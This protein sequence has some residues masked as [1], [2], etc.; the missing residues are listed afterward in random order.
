MTSREAGF[1]IA[2]L[3]L[4]APFLMFPALAGAGN[5]ELVAVLAM[6]TLAGAV[7]LARHSGL[8]A[9][10]AALVAPP[11]ALFAVTAVIGWGLSPG[12]VASINHFSGIG[13][14]L[15]AMAILA[16]WCQSAQRLA[17][18]TAAVLVM[19]VVVLSIGFRST[20][21]IHKR[22]VFLSDTKAVPPPVIPLPLGGIHKNEVVNPNAL[23]AT[24]MMIL[25]VGVAVAATTASLPWS[26]LMRALG[27]GSALWAAAIVALMQSRS[28]WLSAIIV[29]WLWSRSWLG[30]RLWRVVTVVMV[31]IGGAAFFFL[32]DHPRSG[33]V[34]STLAGRM[35]VWSDACEALK[36]S[37]WLGI[38]LD[39]FRNSGYSMVLWPPNQ[40]VGVPHAHNI[41]LQTALDIGLIGLA[42]YLMLLGLVVVRGLV[43]IRTRLG[44]GFVRNVGMA[45][46]LSVISVH[47][48]GLLDAVS[49]GAKVG[50]FQW[51]SCGLILAAWQL[52]TG[53]VTA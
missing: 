15:Y 32:K 36:T 27:M 29:G 39:H 40:M 20:P 18:A 53:K 8:V 21:A 25:P 47:A 22:K 49:V 28:A 9:L 17:L 37:P 48:Y 44:P 34:I 19:G 24:A 30:P 51:L 41:F 5:V 11:A 26:W 7:V 43:F 14:G 33:E 35:N 52:R 4:V 42:G 12:Q 50:I 2:W 46:T 38:G 6:I 45:A 31:V 1:A 23:S 13:L 16:A 10:P 3:V